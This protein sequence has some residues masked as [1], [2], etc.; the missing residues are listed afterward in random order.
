MDLIKLLS[1]SLLC[2]Y[3]IIIFTAFVLRINAL[4]KLE[5]IKYSR[6][7]WEEKETKARKQLK[8]SNILFLITIIWTIIYFAYLHFKEII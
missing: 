5:L 6:F 4:S 2:T 1:V 3:L 7:S 8:I